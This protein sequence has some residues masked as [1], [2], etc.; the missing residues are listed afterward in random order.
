MMGIEFQPELLKGIAGK[1]WLLLAMC[2]VTQAAWA[3]WAGFARFGA[4]AEVAIQERAVHV[5]LRLLDKALPALAR[6]AAPDDPASPPEQIASH[7][8]ALNDRAGHALPG[9]LASLRKIA[10]G[11]D[12]YYEAELEFV[13]PERA[14]E[15]T[16][17]PPHGVAG[18]DIGM[19][20]LH[21][22]VPVSDLVA[23]DKAA[24]LRLDWSDPWQ[25]RF[26]DAA[27]ARHHAEPRSFIYVEPYEVRHEIMIRAHDLLARL[28]FH[29]A[30]PERLTAT[31]RNALKQAIGDYLTHHNP[32]RIDG[33]AVAP[34]LDRVEFI[35]FDRRGVQV[36]PDDEPLDSATALAGVILVYLT[37][38]PA[39]AIE[40]EWDA[41]GKADSRRQVSVQYGIESF[42]SYVTRQYPLF[43]WS[44]DDVFDMAE[45]Q[46]AIAV[47][48]HP[49]PRVPHGLDTAL[50][51]LGAAIALAALAQPL[52]RRRFHPPGAAAELGLLL[53]LA[54]CVGFYPE[55]VRVPDAAAATTEPLPE[56]AAKTEL[57]A[58]LHNVYR[59][60]QIRGEDAAYDRLALSL[61]GDILDEIYLRQRR[62]LQQRDRGLGGEGRVN[63][64][65][66]LDS[67]IAHSG[68]RDMRIA[69][70]WVAHGT[71]SHWGHSHER[72][73]EYQANFVLSPALDG[74]WKITSL[75]FLEA[76]RRNGAGSRS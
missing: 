50:R 34:Q 67:R 29:P 73:N 17:A 23:L 59:A 7:L 6:L 40:L 55:I 33:A 51:Y 52:R 53:A 3:D 63:R 13:P 30:H 1:L 26:D 62:A 14:E 71:V 2:A 57:H 58:L 39:H 27:F 46:P 24:T 9:R 19:I 25:S 68:T 54:G 45:D 44:S 16:I 18:T 48:E 41:F 20:A 61:D 42:D 74:R 69:A 28:D 35:R 49:T 70:R 5:N 12:P 72:S 4:V 47:P 56:D 65:E 15:L 37:D 10:A 22:G 8:L 66:V 60:F 32:L 64:I 43:Q 31:E 21:R 75:E 76:R 36:L 38:Q 11:P